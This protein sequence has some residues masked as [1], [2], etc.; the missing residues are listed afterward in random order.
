MPDSSESYRNMRSK[1]TIYFEVWVKKRNVINVNLSKGL[2]STVIKK[3][4]DKFALI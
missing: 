2:L 1:T 4:L 3:P